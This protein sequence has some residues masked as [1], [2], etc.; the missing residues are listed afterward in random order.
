MTEASFEEIEYLFTLAEQKK[1]EIS[2]TLIEANTIKTDLINE[3]VDKENCFE[4]ILESYLFSNEFDYKKCLDFFNENKSII[5][6]NIKSSNKKISQLYIAYYLFFIHRTLEEYEFDFEIVLGGDKTHFTYDK[7]EILSIIHS[8]LEKYKNFNSKFNFSK[9]TSFSTNNR[10]ISIFLKYKDITIKNSTGESH[11]MKGIVFNLRLDI[12]SL[13]DYLY[14]SIFRTQVTKKEILACYNFSHSKGD[15]NSLHEDLCYG[16]SNT[17]I[18]I[19]INSFYN[20]FNESSSYYSLDFNFLTK[21]FFTIDSYLRWESL[22]GTPYKYIKNLNKV[23]SNILLFSNKDFYYTDIKNYNEILDCLITDEGKKWLEN[24][25]VI[26]LTEDDRNNSVINLDFTSED[27][28]Y[29]NCLVKPRYYDNKMVYASVTSN[30]DVN[31]TR[32]FLYYGINGEPIYNE[33]VSENEN[34]VEE[35]K[36]ITSSLK[37]Q[38]I[39][40]IKHYF[41]TKIYDKYI[42]KIE[43]R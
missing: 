21:L 16:A 43:N 31:F 11:L 40:K 8:N 41:N 6:K 20:F 39:D 27:F 10:S 32:K 42:E 4:D 13:C 37:T 1:K 33:L 36:M 23:K 3:T 22:E 7:K 5:K 28:L 24:N 12:V 30:S 15:Y 35:T 34:E 18:N 25:L 14:N 19:A 9:Q 2:E 17:E 26:N 29:D 38:L